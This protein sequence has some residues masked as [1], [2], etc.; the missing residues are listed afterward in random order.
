M[1]FKTVST[2]ALPDYCFR[3]DIGD[4]KN[5]SSGMKAM[6]RKPANNGSSV[7][8]NGKATG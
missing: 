7:E 5:T 2:L 3:P 8:K 6:K 4:V 1:S